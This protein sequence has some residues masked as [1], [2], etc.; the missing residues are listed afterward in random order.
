MSNPV[1]E[2]GNKTNLAMVHGE[3]IMSGR[4][5]IHSLFRVAALLILFMFGIACLA[6]DQAAS[7]SEGLLPIQD[8]S[9]DLWTRSHLTGDWGGVR[10]DW[11]NNGVTME[12]DWYQVYQDIIDGGISEGSESSTNLDY[13]LNLD[14]M[15]MGI[16]PGAMV[17]IRAQSRF[18][19]TVNGASGLLLPVNMYSTFPLSSDSDGEVDFAITEFNWTQ[20]LSENFGL[21]VGKVTTTATANEFMGG[22]GQRQFMNFQLSFPAPTAQLAPYSTLA[23]GA[24]WMPSPNWTVSTI[25]MN[26]DDAST[27]SGFD[28]IGD[29]TTWAT[30]ADYLASLN[31][32]PGGGSFGFFYGF[33]AEFAQIGGLN[34]NPGTGVSTDSKSDAWAL[35]WNGW[36]YLVAE[37]GSGAVDPRNG[38]QDL[39]GLGMFATLGLGDKDTNPVSWSIAGGLSGRGSIPGRDADTWG[40]GYF[41]NDLQDLDRRILVFENSISG[42]ELYYDIAL[43]GSTSLTFDAQWTKSAFPSVDN[44]TIF[45]ARMNMRF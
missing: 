39:Q 26:L 15:R 17:T 40:A 31:D 24:L 14:L 9:G 7:A 8:Y 22:Q 1:T 20:F 43:M 34:I 4:K 36:Q 13:R 33:D 38:R 18:G 23:V 11:A 6:D 3:T 30:N 2:R 10:Q 12:L 21:I 41:Y 32:L 42:L 28:D 37:E 44:A 5:R 16:V 29:G 25:F 19:D 35:S 27:T 45:G